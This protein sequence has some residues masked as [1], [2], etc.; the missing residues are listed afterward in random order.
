VQD[1]T[2]DLPESFTAQLI[3]MVTSGAQKRSAV[4]D[5][6]V[7]NG[8]QAQIAVVTRGPEYWARALRWGR[9]KK[10][11]SETDIGILQLA[12]G[13]PDRLSERQCIRL[14]ET[15]NRLIEEGFK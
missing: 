2:V 7:V 15:D 13:A 14:L 12:S 1:T 6:R 5:Q 10:Y 9:E 4:K 11:L 3:P 8:I